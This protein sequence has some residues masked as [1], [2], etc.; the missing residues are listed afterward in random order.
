MSWSISVKEKSGDSHDKIAKAITNQ[1]SPDNAAQR[2]TLTAIL[3]YLQMV[4]R[5]N[6]NNGN[7]VVMSSVGHVEQSGAGSWDIHIEIPLPVPPK[8]EK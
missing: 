7:E 6:H 4:A 5:D 8:E 3:S 2:L 1:I